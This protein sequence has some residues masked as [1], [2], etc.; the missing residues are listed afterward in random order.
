MELLDF[1]LTLGSSSRSPS[2]ELRTL[3][4]SLTAIGLFTKLPFSALTNLWIAV[5]MCIVCI[6]IAFAEK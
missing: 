4:N 5:T 2:S 6:C 1:H 3:Q